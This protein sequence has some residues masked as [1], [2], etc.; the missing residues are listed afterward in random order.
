MKEL[1]LLSLYEERI[2]CF[3]TVT[4]GRTMRCTLSSRNSSR[5][6]ANVVFTGGGRWARKSAKERV[7]N[8]S[9]FCW[10]VSQHHKPS[11]RQRKIAQL[12]GPSRPQPISDAF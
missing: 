6:T 10:T 2:L 4:R 8:Q 1:D 5:V 11:C 12:A 3:Q 7:S 9:M